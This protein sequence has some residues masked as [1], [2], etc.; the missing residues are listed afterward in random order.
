MSEQCPYC[1]EKVFSVAI[2]MAVCPKT[3]VDVTP[4]ERKFVQSL[5]MG[6][7]KI[8]DSA[9]VSAGRSYRAKR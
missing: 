9:M 8:V 3:A 5:E 4:D 7:K 6:L 2:H 1:D